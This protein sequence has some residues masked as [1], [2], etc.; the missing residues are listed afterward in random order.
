MK[1]SG[2]DEEWLL[3]LDADMGIASGEELQALLRGATGPSLRI[4]GSAVQR[5]HT[6]VLQLLAA[7]VRERQ[8]AGRESSWSGA[9]QV[10]Q[11]AARLLGISRTLNL[12]GAPVSSPAAPTQ[13]HG[14]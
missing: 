9:S 12:E 5:I 1:R 8:Q 4:D 11:E 10:L 6:A 3:Q 7:C 13:Q 2:S 14:E